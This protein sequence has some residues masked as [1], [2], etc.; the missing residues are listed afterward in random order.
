MQSC[1][2]IFEAPRFGLRFEKLVS[3]SDFKRGSRRVSNFTTTIPPLEIYPFDHTPPPHWKIRQTDPPSPLENP[4]PSVGGYGYFLQLHN[5]VQ[6]MSLS[7]YSSEISNQRTRKMNACFLRSSEFVNAFENAFLKRVFSFVIQCFMLLCFH[8]QKIR[9]APELPI[10]INTLQFAYRYAQH[11]RTT[12]SRIN[13]ESIWLHF[14]FCVGLSPTSNLN[15]TESPFQ[16]FKMV[17][18]A[19]VLT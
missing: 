3:A 9:N 4:I 15:I 10:C 2:R 18:E 14:C 19:V 16:R 12:D 1:A 11:L 13:A 5:K 6:Y 7:Q 17:S 8:K